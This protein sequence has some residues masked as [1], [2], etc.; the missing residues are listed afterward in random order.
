MRETP[1][2]AEAAQSGITGHRRR[3]LIGLLLVNCLTGLNGA[4]VATAAAALVADLG[5]LSTFPFVFSGHFLAA[6]VALPVSGKLADQYGRRSPMTV[7][8]SVFLIGSLLCGLAWNM[9]SLIGFRIIQGL[10]AGAMMSLSAII[11]GDLYTGVQRARAQAWASATFIGTYALGPLIG[12][13]VIEFSTW[14]WSFFLNL[15][16][17]LV[18]LVLLF[19]LNEDAVRTSHRFDVVGAVLLTASVTVFMVGLTQGGVWWAWRSHIS[20]LL[21]A[22]TLLLTAGL[23]VRER[24]AAEP[25]VPP[26][27]FQSR[28]LCASGLIRIICGVIGISLPALL[29]YLAQSIPGV[30]PVTASASLTALTLSWSVCGLVSAHFA[31]GIGVRNTVLLGSASWLVGGLLSVASIESG[32]FVCLCLSCGLLGIGVGLIVAPTFILVQETVSSA[33]RGVATSTLQF[34]QWVGGAVGTAALGALI[35]G[36]SNMR[37]VKA[38][39]EFANCPPSSDFANQAHLHESL[40]VAARYAFWG[41]A[42]L[43][44]A[45]VTVTL[46]F[47]RDF[48]TTRAPAVT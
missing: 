1:A 3:I 11:L 34:A 17:T 41:V 24:Q 22:T 9:L 28:L 12:G 18:A 40:L 42:L 19:G 31:L 7:A 26:W 48:R 32:S 35:N 20:V 4:V 43:G 14:R 2:L 46:A 47:S 6:A 10:G 39:H 30:T 8:V 33:R 21:L 45:A 15:P 36:A 13:L 16:V 25:I 29:P 5:G 44:L 38:P 27:V 23:V 37:W